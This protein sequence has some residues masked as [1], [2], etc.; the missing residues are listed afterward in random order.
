[1]NHYSARRRQTDGRFD[2][3]VTTDGF[4]IPVGY[5]G[6]YRPWTSEDQRRFPVPPEVLKRSWA[7]SH[8]HHTDGHATPEEAAACYR[9]FLL[10]QRLRTGLKNDRP[11]TC[12]ECGARTDLYAAV[13]GDRFFILCEPHNDREVVAR[14]FSPPADIWTS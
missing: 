9:E 12:K 10:D 11:D 14:H 8:K 7:H 4:T 6:A 2:F 5:C 3:T 1:M 13:D